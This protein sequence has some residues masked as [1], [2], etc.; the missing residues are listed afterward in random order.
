MARVP[1]TQRGRLSACR[2]NVQQAEQAATPERDLRLAALVASGQARS[3]R[4]L[5]SQLG[6]SHEWVRQLVQRYGLVL[7]K[8]TKPLPISPDVTCSQCETSFDP[9]SSW[10]GRQRQRTP[11]CSSCKRTPLVGL[12]CP[13]C[14][15]TRQLPQYAAA[16]HRTKLC[17]DCYRRIDPDEKLKYGI[18]KRRNGSRVLDTCPRCGL[19]RLLRTVDARVRRTDLCH[20]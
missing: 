7:Q 17:R 4:G 12:T 14:G 5:A 2:D 9:P 16:L 11:L 13:V 6:I 19:E 3:Y 10:R 18:K 20:P 15:K 1:R 8:P